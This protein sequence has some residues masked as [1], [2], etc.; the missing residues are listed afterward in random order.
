MMNAFQ[1]SYWQYFMTD[2]VFISTAV[3]GICLTVGT[4]F[5]V[6]SVFTTG[7]MMEAIRF[8]KKKFRFWLTIT[9][10]FITACFLMMFTNWG[11]SE[12]LTASIMTFGYGVMNFGINA[13]V[14]CRNLV[15]SIGGKT[16]KKRSVLSTKKGQGSS[17]GTFVFGLI[18]FNSIMF[19]SGGDPGV[20]SG[21]FG[22]VLMFGT[23]LMASQLYLAR[24][25]PQSTIEDER[26]AGKGSGHLSLK[27][28]LSSLKASPPFIAI[29]AADSIRYISRATMLGIVAYYFQ[30]VLHDLAASAFFF[31]AAGIIAMIGAFLSE[32]LVQKISKRALYYTG[33]VTMISSLLLMFLFGLTV[34][35]FIL[36]AC[37]YYFGLSFVNSGQI[38]LYSDGI[39]Y[40]VY[41]QKSDCRIWLMSLTNLCPS[42]GNFGRA[43]VVGLGLAII[44]YSAQVTP[45]P[46]VIMGIRI[47]ACIVPASLMVIGIF[48]LY[49]WFDLSDKKMI[50]IREEL[51]SLGLARE[52][53]E[54][55]PNTDC[56]ACPTDE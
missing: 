32:I 17:V 14:T 25:F 22:A 40:A 4:V 13:A 50:E 33:Y 51:M 38:G 46:E 6:L 44:G 55:L 3:A 54:A 28:M 52:D 11:F 20:P 15:V 12:V 8:P 53:N 27:W 29:L 37:L 45:T 30:Y 24:V 34:P 1:S 9:A 49:K 5:E 10:P 19:F 47:L 26:K 39:D 16:P 21:Y 43:L 2:V 48:V 31:S 42:L 7:P 23:L 56:P 35:A 36:L 18:G 41:K